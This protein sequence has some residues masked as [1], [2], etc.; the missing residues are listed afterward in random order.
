MGVKELRSIIDDETAIYWKGYNAAV[1]AAAQT[2]ENHM[3]DKFMG[4][5]YANAAALVRKCR[6]DHNG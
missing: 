3:P 1:E 6:F 5:T 4:V 2:L